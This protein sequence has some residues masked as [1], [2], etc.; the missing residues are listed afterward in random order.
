MAQSTGG[1]PAHWPNPRERGD[2]AAKRL[3]DEVA[4]R[5]SDEATKR[6]SDVATMS[7]Y[8]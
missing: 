4:K 8:E 5:R 2:E 1:T 6:R 7:D 3:R